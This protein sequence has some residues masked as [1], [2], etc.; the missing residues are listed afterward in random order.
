[1]T[2]RDAASLP[3]LYLCRHGQTDWNADGRLQGQSDIPL[4]STGRAQASRNGTYLRNVLGEA[5][6]TFDFVSSPMGRASET[7]RIIRR[8]LRLPEDDFRR[9]ER[10]REIHFGDWQGFTLA[11][12]KARDPA[13]LATR[14]RDK[15]NFVPPGEGAEN[16]SG[17]SAR[18]APVFEAL[19]R[20]TIMTA[21]GGI[22]RAFLCLYGGVS[23]V[24][25]AQEDIHQ[26]RIL[27]VERGILAWV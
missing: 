18:V 3:L 1:M 23:E 21:H 9:D 8:T 5:A 15:W 11:E 14:K 26:D 7:M 17:L 20:P 25:A 4:N 6:A 2:P 22:T 13:G 24:R 16:Y 10:L 27:R 12:V 19:D